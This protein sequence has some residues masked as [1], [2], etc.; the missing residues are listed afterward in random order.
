MNRDNNAVI[1]SF[2]FVYLLIVFTLFGVISCIPTV[3]GVSHK[4]GRYITYFVFSI[5]VTCFCA[6]LS[7]IYFVNGMSIY[8]A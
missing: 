3:Y 2:F 6:A 7:V 5:I 8:G 1:A 4:K